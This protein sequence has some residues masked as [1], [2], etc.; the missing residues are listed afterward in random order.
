MNP[1]TFQQLTEADPRAAWTGAMT[2]TQ[3]HFKAALSVA[4]Y[5]SISDDAQMS[6]IWSCVVIH[7]DNQHGNPITFYV[8]PEGINL[9]TMGFKTDLEVATDCTPEDAT[10]AGNAVDSN[11]YQE[12][13]PYGGG[14]EEEGEE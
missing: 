14:D 6:N 4:G 5:T 8:K 11:W 3:E 7:A 1:R 12:Y 10:V 9:L 13:D 2:G